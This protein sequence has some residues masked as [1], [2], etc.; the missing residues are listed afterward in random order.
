M[1][2]EKSRMEDFQPVILRFGIHR[3]SRNS[4]SLI[5]DV[6]Y[7]IVQLSLNPLLLLSRS[8]LH[9]DNSYISHCYT[10]FSAFI[11][12]TLTFMTSSLHYTVPLLARLPIEAKAVKNP[13]VKQRRKRNTE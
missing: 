6:Y 8:L 2:G 4:F 7:E 1:A 3:R 12:I 10:V 5:N 13:D 9:K 11:R